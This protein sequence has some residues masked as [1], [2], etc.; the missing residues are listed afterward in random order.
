MAKKGTPEYEIWKAKFSKKR[1][2]II[3]QA[4]S[5][6]KDPLVQKLKK[7]LSSS[8]IEEKD[9]LLFMFLSD[10]DPNTL[11][12]S[13]LDSVREKFNIEQSEFENLV[14]FFRT[15]SKDILKLRLH[16]VNNFYRIHKDFN[17]YPESFREK[18]TKQN[19]VQKYGYNLDSVIKAKSL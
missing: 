10:V 3:A 5:F 1:A 4:N 9:L 12:V 19:F 8:L 18:Y 15:L 16:G 14:G 17:S 13:A 6:D 2:E 11:S 7:N